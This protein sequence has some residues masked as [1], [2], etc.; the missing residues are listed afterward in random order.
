M[1]IQGSINAM[2]GTVAGAMTASVVGKSKMFDDDQVKNDANQRAVKIAQQRKKGKGIDYSK[3]FPEQY[4]QAKET[5]EAPKI[6]NDKVSDEKPTTV[7]MGEGAKLS[8][9]EKRAILNL[10]LGRNK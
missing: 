4:S 10:N 5:V 6:S 7:Q 1:A 3:L 2:L 9:E 8:T